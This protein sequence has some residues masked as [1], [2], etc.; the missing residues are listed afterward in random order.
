VLS[1]YIHKISKHAILGYNILIM[2]L[3]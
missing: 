2:A 3:I 1:K